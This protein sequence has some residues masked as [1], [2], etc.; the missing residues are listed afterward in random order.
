VTEDKEPFFWMGGTVWGM[1]ESLTREEV[2][3]YLDNRKEKGFN[4][5]QVCLFWGKREDNPVR[6]TLNPPNAYGFKAFEETNGIPDP[7]KPAHIRKGSPQEPDDYWDHAEY[8]IQAAEKRNMAVALLP[9]WGR[10][11]VNGTHNNFSHKIFSQPAMHS[12]GKFLGER[13]RDYS[14][15]IWVMGG[16]VAADLGGDF[17]GH[18]RAMAEGIIGG[19]TGKAVK[20]NEDSKLWDFA[21]MTYH[22]DGSPL[23]NSSMWFHKDRWLDFNMIETHSNRDMVYTA[24]TND[25]V[26]D[27]PVKPTVMAEPGYEGYL[28]GSKADNSTDVQMRRQAFHS[29]FAGAAGFT[30]GAACDSLGNG[31]LF[32]PFKGWQMTLDMKGAESMRF[33]KKFCL[34]HNWPEWIPVHDIVQSNLKKSEFQKVAVITSLKDEY[35]IYF[36][37]TSPAKL[38]MTLYIRETEKLFV[39]WYNPASGIYTVKSVAV[40]SGG[41][42]VVTP[43]VNWTD[44][45]LILSGIIR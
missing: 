35:L 23:K 18:Y 13:F 40:F 20:W 43:P 34:N 22:P 10:R 33:V 28:P 17:S 15:I 37:D 41:E 6:F 16:D 1:C 12:Y 24:V 19:L 7:A 31:P 45:I 42:L 44:A 3:F 26:L 25:Y 8:V 2:D 36:P 21:L 30:Y 38:D 32:S 29:F 4:L 27:K 5:V 9:L 11:Y 14:N 39:Q